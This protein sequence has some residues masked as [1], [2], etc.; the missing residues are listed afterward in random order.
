MTSVITQKIERYLSERQALGLYRSRAMDNAEPEYLDFSCNDY[1]SLTTDLRVKKAY[2]VGCELF[3]IGSG[4]SMVLSGYHETHHQLEQDFAAALEVDDC[5][6]FSSGYVANL[7]VVSLLAH[8]KAHVLIDKSVHASVYDGLELAKAPYS[9]FLHNDVSDLVKKLYNNEN[10]TMIMTESVFSMSGL[11]APLTEIA[12]LGKEMV[13][14]E[15]H[16]FGVL[17][18]Q[19]LGGTKAA[20]LT[21]DQVPLR[22]IPF[23]KAL[24]ASGAIVAGKA[25]WIDALLQ[26][27]RQPVY[28]TAISPAFAYGIRETLA[29]L[30]QADDRRQHLQ[31]LIA[32]FRQ[33]IQASSLLWRDSVT[34]IQQLQLGCPFLATKAARTLKH[35][36]IKCFPIRQPTVTKQETGLRVILNYHHTQQDIDRL[37]QALHS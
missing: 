21:Q 33:C 23:G 30:R 3:P 22:V 12:A 32:Y 7:S 11:C 26:S 37:F 6:L 2:Q 28:S 17:G 27:T 15:A 14:D 13:V 19:G 9:R 20:G 4:G 34:P 16:G 10:T 36:G 29:I 5:L 8:F 24:G 1:L 25:A 31:G 18:P 35:H